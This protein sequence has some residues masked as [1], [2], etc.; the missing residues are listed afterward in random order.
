MLKSVARFVLF[1]SGMAISS[2]SSIAYGLSERFD[3]LWMKAP[4]KEEADIRT[5]PT[6]ANLIY[7]FLPNTQ[8][9]TMRML[10]FSATNCSSLVAQIALPAAAF[11]AGQIWYLP[12]VA[13]K[14]YV[15]AVTFEIGTASAARTAQS[16]HVVD[17]TAESTG[18]C[19]QLTPGPVDGTDSTSDFQSTGTPG[20]LNEGA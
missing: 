3:D 13:L 15:N 11:S 2:S 16:F 10:F 4:T 7:T 6:G 17:A 8:T 5:I 12:G 20:V 18:T 1:A 9:K 19:T 14:A